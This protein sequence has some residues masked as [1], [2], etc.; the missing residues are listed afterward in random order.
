MRPIWLCFWLA[1]FVLDGAL[2]YWWWHRKGETRFDS[3]IRQAARRY[4]VPPA[5][6]KAV[7]WRES[8]FKPGA[9]GAAGEIGL[10]QIR[11]P[12]ALEWAFAEKIKPFS[13][14][15]LV[16]PS[17]NIS[18]GTWYLG[19]LVKRYQRTDHPFAYALAD[20]NAGRAHVLRWMRG[21]AST[22]CAA[23]LAQMDYPGTQQYVTAVIG[24]AREYQPRMR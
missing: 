14:E 20:Y 13:H 8:A 17:T 19:Q 7:V 11:E 3:Q 23:F 6:V 2:G 9:R 24:R 12:A 18:A 1:L 16:H 5:L 15:T 21:P 10:M 4:G 22:N